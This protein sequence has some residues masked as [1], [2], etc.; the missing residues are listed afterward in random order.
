MSSSY[1][2]IVEL[3]DGDYALQRMDADDEEP[4]VIISFSDEVSE[5][6]QENQVAVAKAMIGAGVQAA[7][8]ISKS[9]ADSEEGAEHG[10]PQ[11]KTLH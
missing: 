10:A 1:L 6:L 4:L 5:Y 2:E 8:S 3:E 9:M 7:G 11:N